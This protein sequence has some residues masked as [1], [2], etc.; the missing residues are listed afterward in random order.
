MMQLSIE[1]RLLAGTRCHHRSP[2][3]DSPHR[4]LRR[5]EEG[6]AAPCACLQPAR[7]PSSLRAPCK[8]QSREGLFCKALLRSNLPSCSF[9][10]S[11]LQGFELNPRSEMFKRSRSRGIFHFEQGK[12]AWPLLKHTPHPWQTEI[13]NGLSPAP[14]SRLIKSSLKR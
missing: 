4:A 8:E 10:P 3:S 12:C 6:C 13:V 7:S 9:L 11:T 2:G 14:E 5:R 1:N